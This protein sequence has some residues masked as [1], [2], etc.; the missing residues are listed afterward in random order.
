MGWTICNSHTK[1]EDLVMKIAVTGATGFIGQYVVK[2]LERISE[3]P[4]IVCLPGSFIPSNFS[5]LDKVMIDVRTPPRDSFNMIG[6][7]DALMH[8]AWG[9]LPNYYSSHH[10]EKELPAHFIFL[11]GLIESGLKN[12]LVTGTCH[13]YGM[14]SGMLNE[15][16]EAQPINS[17]GIA[18]DRL[19]RQLEDLQQFRHFNLSWVRLFYIYG[20]GQ[21]ADSLFSQLKRAIECREKEFNMSG[22]DQIRDYLHVSE[23][24]RYI[25]SLAKTKQNNGIVNICSGTPISIRELVEGWLKKY[26][27]LIK[28]KLGFYPYPDY[29]PMAFW[30]DNSRLKFLLNA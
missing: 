4:V 25:V 15:E 14:A 29:E 16:I 6:R 2:E 23:A 10:V 1:F 21:S 27:W 9:G 24:A 12:L 11:K 20:Y 13:E 7:P 17:Y 3:K 26:K 18:K 19:R 22:G 30:G 5:H 28:L 8:L